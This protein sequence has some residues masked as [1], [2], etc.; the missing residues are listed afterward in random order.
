MWALGC[1]SV[2][3]LTGGLAF[4]DPVTNTY[5][6]KLAR[7]CNL[8]FLRK[9]KDWKLVRNRPRDFVEKLLVLDEAARMTAEEAFAHSWFTNQIHKDDF[10]ELYQRTIKHWRPRIPKSPIIDFQDSGIIKS[11]RFS[12][13]FRN[14]DKSHTRSPSPIDPPYKPFP[15]SMHLS[16]WPKRDSSRRLSE[17]V[18]STIKNWSPESAH[19]LSMSSKYTSTEERPPTS[20]LRD[21]ALAWGSRHVRA[22]SEP[23]PDRSGFKTKCPL[24]AGDS[25]SSTSAIT[26]CKES[27][28]PHSA[29]KD[30]DQLVPVRRTPT[31]RLQGSFNRDHSTWLSSTESRTRN[32]ATARVPEVDRVLKERRPTTGV[33]DPVVQ[34]SRIPNA[35]RVVQEVNRSMSSLD[36]DGDSSMSSATPQPQRKLKRRV[37]TPSIN[38]K[39]M[40]RRESIFDLAEDG[41]SDGEPPFRKEPLVHR[42]KAALPKPSGPTRLYLP[43]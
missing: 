19:S 13:E 38:Q 32:A 3:L 6:A 20:L 35:L 28:K 40:K 22:Y 39:R 2:V 31:P 1:V 21:K 36:S 4:A 25:Y 8:E 43:R 10:E 15:R 17:E 33:F 7:D 30:D 18:L 23:P 27:V 41:D 29:S 16:L 37:S 12:E 42:P 14:M 11:L 24:T 9:S 34:S 26:E 5:S